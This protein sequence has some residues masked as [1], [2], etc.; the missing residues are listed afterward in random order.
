MR[1]DSAD[2]VLREYLAA[3]SDPDAEQ[4]LA[5]I[6]G[7]IAR[8]IVAR[9]VASVYR[10]TTAMQDA[11]DVVADTLADLLQRLR[12]LRGDDVQPIRDLRGYISTSAYNRCHARLRE[13]YPARNRLRNQ[14][15]YLCGQH[16]RLAVWRG[17]QGTL[18]CG[19]REWDG[20]EP[21]EAARAERVSLAARSDPAAENRAQLLTLVP[22]VLRDV[23]APLELDTLVD[24]VARLIH[25]EQ[26]RVEVPLTAVAL[27]ETPADTA[28]ELRASLRQLWDDVGQLAPKQRAALLLNLRDAHGRECLSLLPLTRTATIA[29]IA[30]AVEMPA[31]RFA[32]LWNEL[33]LS[34]AAIAELLHATARQVIKLRRLARERLR[35][36][37]KTRTRRNLGVE[38]DS[39]SA[40]DLALVTRGRH[41]R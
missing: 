3:F 6:L 10:G 16:A 23:G 1:D 39:S 5:R 7:E 34:D 21:V 41:T 2:A 24:T 36:M 38:L 29:E 8:P 11:E 31:E 26:Q 13:R 4:L 28:M 22:A 33:P 12:D 25:L 15:Q 20:R 37:E 19:L 17:A 32:A 40:T 35:R 18:V 30:A 27:T 14:V 9:I